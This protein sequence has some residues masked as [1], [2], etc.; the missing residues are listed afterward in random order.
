MKEDLIE[1]LTSIVFSRPFSRLL[2]CFCRVCT[3]DQEEDFR[4]NLKIFGKL[5]PKMIGIGQYFTLDASSKIEQIFMDE[6]IN[7]N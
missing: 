1:T 5:R 4:Q 2:I 3:Y 7:E 6:Q